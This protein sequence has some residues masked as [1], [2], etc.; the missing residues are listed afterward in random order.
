AWP[1]RVRR[2]VRAEDRGVPAAVPLCDALAAA[3]DAEADRLVEPEARGVLRDDRGLERPD[4]LAGCAREQP[5]EERAA[6]PAAAVCL[7]DVHRVLDNP[8]VAPA[9]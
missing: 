7:V 4:P 6:D 5:H 8:H 2:A 3:D 1:G 9:R